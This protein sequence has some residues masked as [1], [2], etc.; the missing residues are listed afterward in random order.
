[1]PRK[2]M[3]ISPRPAFEDARI[4]AEARRRSEGRGRVTA[5]QLIQRITDSEDVR[6]A[7]SMVKHVGSKALVDKAKE[8]PF[9]EATV[10]WML[11]SL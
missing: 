4:R 2:R 9:A 1:M 11:P 7:E 8:Y 3:S 10:S 5:E 6:E